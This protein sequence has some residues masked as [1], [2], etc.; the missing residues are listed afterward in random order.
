M[1]SMINNI[2]C[3][4]QSVNKIP[5]QICLYMFCSDVIDMMKT[6]IFPSN[7]I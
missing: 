7:I 4:L 5:N 3:I 1:I 2:G 6:D